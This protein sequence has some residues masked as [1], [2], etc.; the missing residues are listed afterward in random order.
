METNN[1]Q[2]RTLNE[3][4]AFEAQR[5]MRLV[6]ENNQHGKDLAMK[7]SVY[8]KMDY[9]LKFWQEKDCIKIMKQKVSSIN[10]K[11]EPEDIGD[12][13]DFEDVN[14][15]WKEKNSQQIINGFQTCKKIIDQDK[16]ST[17]PLSLLKEALKKLENVIPEE[18][19]RSNATEAMSISN[20]I[21]TKAKSLFKEFE[22]IDKNKAVDKWKNKLEGTQEDD[23]DSKD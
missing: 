1:E 15:K 8:K 13:Q 2:D 5:C 14:E 22:Y 7:G 4:I 10:G 18:L 23:T 12:T 19:N 11:L 3:N 17:T 21:Q 6:V 16:E 9:F 20:K